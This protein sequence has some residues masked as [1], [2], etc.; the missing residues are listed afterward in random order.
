[1]GIPIGKLS[2]YVACAGINPAHTL[3]VTIDVGTNTQRLIDDPMYLGEKHPRVG[4]DEYYQIIEEFIQAATS[5]WPDVLIQF[6]DFSND[7]CFELLEKYRHRTLCFNDDIQGT[8]AVA[9]AG[10]SKYPARI[11]CALLG[12]MAYKDA[13]VQAQ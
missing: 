7:H 1:M 12:W 6:E 8:G 9:L 5:R 3:P 11:K 13:S 2:L 4:G 10:V